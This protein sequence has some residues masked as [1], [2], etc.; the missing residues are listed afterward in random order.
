MVTHFHIL[1]M[2][3]NKFSFITGS[4][5]NS[6]QRNRFPPNSAKETAG[7]EFFSIDVRTIRPD[8]LLKGGR[9]YW[10]RIPR[11]LS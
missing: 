5:D 1:N 6:G 4:V 11:A 9:R 10:V 7:Q 2:E 3:F 8:M